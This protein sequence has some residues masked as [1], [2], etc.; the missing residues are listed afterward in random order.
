MNSN[1]AFKRFIKNKVAVIS[2]IIFMI[3]VLACLIM[4]E[5][6]FN[7]Y[8][9]LNLAEHFAP[10]SLKHPLSTDHLGRDMFTRIL[11]GGRYTLGLSFAAAIISL[12]IGSILGIIAGYRGGIFDTLCMRISEAVSAIPY[13]LIVI[14]FEVALG[15]GKGYFYL[16]IAFAQIP[17][18]LRTIRNAVIKIRFKEFIEASKA[19]G[20][21]DLY[22]LIHHVI[23]NVSSSILV[24]GCVNFASAIVGCAILGYLEFGVKFPTPEWGL[25]VADYYPMIM[26]RPYLAIIPSTFITICVLTVTLTG[27]GLR[28]A[29]DV[30]GE[31]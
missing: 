7:D 20:K 26:S 5:L 10:F 19:L 13:I 8:E 22:I 15:W 18:T 27:N 11:V 21:S 9:T 2:F 1:R 4:P 6:G 23:R 31:Q 29:L 12:T 25:M 3:I 14:A 24:Q 16:A 17:S 30:K 28:D